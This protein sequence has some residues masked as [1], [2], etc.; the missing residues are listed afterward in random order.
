MHYRKICDEL[1]SVD[2]LI[3]YVGILYKNELY[4]K[5]RKGIQNYL[6]QKEN[7]VYVT[8]AVVRKISRYRLARVLGKPIYSI[9]KYKKV[10]AYKFLLESKI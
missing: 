8:L 1:L 3:R 10:T 5:M 6:T 7:E 4:D 9:T 2:P